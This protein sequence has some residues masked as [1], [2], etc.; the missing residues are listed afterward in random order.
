MFLHVH[1]FKWGN[2]YSADDVNRLRA[3]FLRN[4]KV[5]HAFHCSTDD[6]KGLRPDIVSHPLPKYDFCNWDIGLGRKLA[7]F[8]KN[9]IGLEGSL[10]IQTDIDVV[11]IGDCS[12]LADRP[13]EDF[14]IGRGKNQAY[15]TRG[16]GAIYRIR[17][18]S[19]THVWNTLTE[20][21]IAA[22]ATAQHHRG[23]RGHISEQRWI[24]AQIK[25]MSFFEDGSIVYFRQD[26]N[27]K[28]DHLNPA[29]IAHPP[30]GAK[31][32]SFAGKAK[33]RQVMH[34]SYLN[35]RH[36]PFVAEHWHE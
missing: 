28:T 27:A 12:F 22:V 8:G 9:F 3:M 20:D 10:L 4:L 1:A 19:Q 17:V 13:E 33:P 6:S 5:P 24:D 30:T 18:G 32:V 36:A 26:C 23:E 2:M 29:G 16:H 34:E 7:V 31:I 15:R 25:N 14:I 11:L 21:P 35:F